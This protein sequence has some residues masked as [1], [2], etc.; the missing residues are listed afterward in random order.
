MSG[1]CGENAHWEYTAATGEVVISGTGAMYDYESGKSPFYLSD[2][3]EIIVRSVKIEKGITTVGDYAFCDCSSLTGVELPEGLKSIG[4]ES[5]GSCDGWKTEVTLPASLVEFDGTAF[6]ETPVTSYKVAAGNASFCSRG[7]A[8]FSSDQ[9]RIVAYPSARTGNYTVPDSVRVIGSEAFVCSRLSS[10]MLPESV[11]EIEGRAFAGSYLLSI[12]LPDHVKRIGDGA[13]S[14]CWNLTDLALPKYLQSIGVANGFGCSSLETV[15]IYQYL[16]DI[17]NLCFRSASKIKLYKNSYAD[18]YCNSFGQSKIE[19]MGTCREIYTDY[20]EYGSDKK[21]LSAA[22]NTIWLVEGGPCGSLPEPEIGQVYKDRYEFDGWYTAKTGGIRLTEDTVF[23]FTGLDTKNGHDIIYAHYREAGGVHQFTYKFG[24]TRNDFGYAPDYTI[25]EE[26]IFTKLWGNTELARQNYDYWTRNFNVWCG[27][28]YGM[29]ATSIMF[30]DNRDD[31]EI[32]GFN[33]RAVLVKE[34]Q[35]ND[36]NRNSGIRMSL[37]DF[38]EIMQV[39]QIDEKISHLIGKSNK[40]KIARLCTA[41]QEAEEENTAILII[42]DSNGPQ[43]AHA[44][45]GYHMEEVSETERRIYIYDCNHPESNRYITLTMDNDTCTGWRYE[46]GDERRSMVWSSEKIGDVSCSISYIT[47][48]SFVKAWLNRSLGESLSSAKNVMTLNV[49][50]ASICDKH[51]QEVAVLEGGEIHSEDEEI[52]AYYPVCTTSDGNYDKSVV[53]PMIYLPTDEYVVKNTDDNVDELK[54][55]MCNV[56]RKAEVS[57]TADSVLVNV[58]DSSKVN[59]VQVE[60]NEEKVEASFYSSDTSEKYKSMNYIGH[61]I[62][63][64]MMLGTAD[65]EKVVKD[66]NVI[67]EKLEEN[68]DDEKEDPNDKKENPD[69]KKEDYP[70]KITSPTGSNKIAAGKKIKL[71]VTVSTKKGRNQ[72]LRYSSS[73]KKVATVNQKGLVTIGKK[74]GG[75]TVVIT[76][77]NLA[78]RKASV[79]LKIMK[80]AVKKIKITGKKSCKA[81]KNLKLKAKVTAGKG[82]NKGVVWKS[83]NTRYAEVTKKGIVKA[84]KK[85]KKVKIT[86]SAMDGSGK[87]ASVKITIK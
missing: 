13:F 2:S 57:T 52:F 81:G 25:D 56:N 50:N 3:G 19:Y 37:L 38:I 55:T 75:K 72:K 6:E 23:D 73:N 5:F 80:G 58:N 34:L 47:Y 51:G 87:K 32:S 62:G 9:T 35:L 85:G 45:V 43:G 44:V 69:N 27:N 21:E 39:S 31:I 54:L 26:S 70:F 59:M 24:N 77:V 46:G 83:S 71:A 53:Q 79:K 14:G 61:V 4:K 17:G 8:V 33:S 67:S 84:K 1:K 12:S 28:C 65:G 42:L 10:L 15:T 66:F 86:A 78:G 41:L 63:S 22:E 36:Y 82:A 30:K 11:Q 76:A 20:G 60:G 68:P 40:G 16:N 7:E 18:E 49:A 48:D 64:S 29:S 74:T